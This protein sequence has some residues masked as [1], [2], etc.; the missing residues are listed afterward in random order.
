MEA[1]KNLLQLEPYN[2]PHSL[3]H[4]FFPSSRFPFQFNLAVLCV[5][6]Q[7]SG[8][9]A[10]RRPTSEPVTPRRRRRQDRKRERDTNGKGNQSRLYRVKKRQADI[11]LS[12][13][14]KPNGIK[15]SSDTNAKPN[16][17]TTCASTRTRS[18]CCTNTPRQ[19][20]VSVSSS[21]PALHWSR[22]PPTCSPTRPLPS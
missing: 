22:R 20:A 1:L 19:R 10:A 12:L 8:R 17:H 15:R 11:S 6:C 3:T 21:P 5:A 14:F 13:S 7:V 2:K 18:G 4:S 9:T 16:V